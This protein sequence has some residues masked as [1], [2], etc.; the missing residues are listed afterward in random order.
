MPRPASAR[1][2]RA[3]GLALAGLAGTLVAVAALAYIALAAGVGQ[4]RLRA[5]AG[6]AVAALFGDGYDVRIGSIGLAL[7]TSARLALEVSDS[8][9]S[10][11]PSGD[12]VMRVDR[13][14]FGLRLLP[15][16]GGDFRVETADLRGARIVLDTLPQGDPGGLRHVI[17]DAGRLDPDATLDALFDGAQRATETLRRLNVRRL[18]LADIEIAASAAARS[19][20]VVS[21][22]HLTRSSGGAL[23]A[24]AGLEYSGATARIVSTFSSTGREPSPVDTLALELDVE[25]SDDGL[26]E[27][28]QHGF[29]AARIAIEGR[30]GEGDE[31][32]RVSARVDGA[33]IFLG[34]NDRLAADLG[35]EGRLRRGERKLE[36]E[37]LTVT[38]GRSTWN[39]HGAVGPEPGSATGETSPGYRFELVSDGSTISP[40][41]ST[42]AALQVVARLA[43]SVSVDGRTVELNQIGVR[44]GQGE[45]SGSATVRFEPGKA[46]GLAL[47]LDVSSMPVGQVKQ[48]WPWF[49]ARGARNWVV[50]NIFGGLVEG[51]RVEL[52]VPPGRMG[53]GVPFGAAEVWGGFSVRG[54]RF[55]VAGHIPPVRDGNGSVNFRGTDVDIALESGTVYMPGG[56]IVN[57][58][59][60]ELAIRSAHINPVIGKLKLDVKGGADAVMALASYDPVDVGRFIDLKPDELTGDVEGV[61]HADVPLQR[62]IPA[63]SLDW[64]V[65]LAYSGLSLSRPFEGQTVA[66][67]NG[68]ILVN[69][70]RAAIEARA[71]LNG[72]PA[73]IQMVEPLGSSPVSRE[74]RISLQLDDKARQA[75]APG[76]DTLLTGMT[77]VELDDGASERRVFKVG[78]AGAT[79]T[80]P[81]A[82][83]SKGQGVPGNVQFAMRTDGD[84][85]DL[86][87]F[88]LS[89]ETFAARGELSLLR[90]EVERIRFPVARLN[91]N[92]EFSFDLTSKGDGYAIA[93]RGRSIDARSVVKLY[94]KDDASTAQGTTSK[95]PVSVD[96]AVESMTGFNGEVFRDV[97]LVYSGTGS[98][99]DRLEFTAVTSNGTPVTFKDGRDGSA[100]S[101]TMQSSD[102]GA[103]LK[104]LD[105][106]EHMQGGSI[107][108]ALAGSGDGP[109]RGQVDARD[110][111]VVN[112]PR[113]NSLVSTAPQ[114]DGRSLNQAVRGEIDTSRVQFQ[115]GFSQIEKGTGYLKLAQ[116][117][118]RG[119]LIGST[120]QGT[121][122]DALGNMDM[123]GTFMPAYGLNRIFGELPLVGAILGNGRDRGLIGITFRLAGKS[124]DP[125][126]QVN[127]LSVIA[128][129]IF[130]SV[131]EYR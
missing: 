71:R 124:G 65:N 52:S 21:R 36:M 92:D 86:T 61:V 74:R 127:P 95:V 121:F 7:D 77:D 79:L 94:S 126:L 131:F 116:G 32:L 64:Q 70:T 68:S 113:L 108:L 63:E 104:F 4:D 44:S 97:K 57:A 59:N 16:I 23:A 91:R 117:V 18:A 78:L 50:A 39:F 128:P 40:A 89:G 118:L 83:W 58:S 107:A 84:R 85:V 100:R 26:N 93:I 41:G 76:L 98:R 110:F 75:L 13:L 56:R 22:A 125:Q 123:T 90:G 129:G 6:K 20:L 42:E 114:N 12:E 47:A 62:D 103:V 2:L 66:D 31:Q 67:A 88:V 5:E 29:N 45:V 19:T 38:S 105:I 30:R 54:T 48:L 101:V 49:A 72:A 81:W 60:G 24:E 96:L 34:D 11:G 9:V 51:G 1:A 130:R 14:R 28:G 15:L 106:Y 53:N 69:P 120:F 3:A 80:I 122:Y 46:P 82:G 35:V 37:R 73:S 10:A 112:E 43:G 111:W 87:D 119:P 17:D 99:T 33:D 109:L 55:D 115:R 8:T 25:P 102:A 27:I